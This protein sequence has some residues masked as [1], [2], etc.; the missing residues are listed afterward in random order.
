MAMLETASPHTR[1]LH[2]TDF[3]YH[4]LI[5]LGVV[6][7]L[8]VIAFLAGSWAWFIAAAAGWGIVVVGQAAYLFLWEAGGG[9]PLNDREAARTMVQEAR[10]VTPGA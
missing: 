5:Y 3:I 8:A 10:K 9:D 2:M 1:A 7:V 6:A 4:V